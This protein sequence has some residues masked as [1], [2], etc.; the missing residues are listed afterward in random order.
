MNTNLFRARLDAE[1]LVPFLTV[2]WS[3]LYRADEPVNLDDMLHSVIDS[4]EEWRRVE[5]LSAVY[6]YNQ[7]ATT[8][9]TLARFEWAGPVVPVRGSLYLTNFGLPK[10]FVVL[11]PRVGPNTV[12]AAYRGLDSDDMLRVCVE[13][14]LSHGADWYPEELFDELPA[15]TINWRPDL[16]PRQL[17]LDGYCAFAERVLGEGERALVEAY[18]EST[19][20][21]EPLPAPAPALAP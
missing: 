19:Y 8:E 3:C 5:R 11:R 9:V 2:R 15:R 17:L 6:L 20:V 1:F 16:L 21:E 13:S 12:V 7:V 14:M 4:D 18:F 10:I